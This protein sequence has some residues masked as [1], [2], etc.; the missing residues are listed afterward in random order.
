MTSG[1]RSRERE[2]ERLRRPSPQDKMRSVLDQLADSARAS[3][4]ASAGLAR[5]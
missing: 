2:E 3:T 5:R 4:R 1:A